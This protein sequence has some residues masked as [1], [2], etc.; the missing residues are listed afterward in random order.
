MKKPFLSK[1]YLSII[2]TFSLFL[3]P[4]LFLINQSIEKGIFILFTLVVWLILF[5]YTR[6]L[7]ISSIL[8]I[9]F[10]LPFNITIQ[11]P[12]VVEFFNTEFLLSTPFVNGVYVN[13]LVPTISIL[14][15]GAFLLLLSIFT[16]KGLF[17]YIN[18]LKSFKN[19]I[20]IFTFPKGQYQRT[21]LRQVL[22]LLLLWFPH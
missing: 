20:F 3:I 8:Y 12:S 14:D 5:I 10:I 13:Y 1:K 2:V 15:L 21:G 4:L 6:K 17:F 19:G 7:I 11:L 9:L 16:E 18:I 22:L